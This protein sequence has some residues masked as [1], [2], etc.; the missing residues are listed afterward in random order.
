MPGLEA[1]LEQLELPSSLDF[2]YAN[3][4][5]KGKRSYIRFHHDQLTKMG[6]VVVGVSLGAT[7]HLTLVRTCSSDT[8]LPGRDGSVDV[9]LRAGSMYVM[10]GISRY[11]L[12]HGVLDASVL[13]D[14]VS[15]TF[16][17]DEERRGVRPPAD[18]SGLVRHPAAGCAC[19]RRS[20]ARPPGRA[21][22]AARR[23]AARPRRS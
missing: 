19:C 11:G 23:G 4:Y 10:S 16:R 14:R 22:A 12:K 21:P 17:G 8:K 1:F 2:L 13:G 18:V 15:L 5:R 20:P 3:R 9:Q 6:P 7:A